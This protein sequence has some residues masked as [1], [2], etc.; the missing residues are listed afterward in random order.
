[1]NSE[2]PFPWGP[3]PCG[4]QRR[5]QPHAEVRLLT[6]P[7]AESCVGPRTGSCGME[8][9]AS[10]PPLPALLEIPSASLFP[11]APKGPQGS[12]E[13]QEDLSWS[14]GGIPALMSVTNPK[15]L[16]GGAPLV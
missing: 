2:P 14:K 16:G 3:T 10:S 11:C 8:G 1:M 7:S 5:T 6:E 13:G 9:P 15:P 4:L 12:W